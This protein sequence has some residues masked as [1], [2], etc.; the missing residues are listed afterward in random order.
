MSQIL[1]KVLRGVAFDASITIKVIASTAIYGDLIFETQ[2]TSPLIT[3][4]LCKVCQV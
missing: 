1:G 4:H 3:Q 2:L